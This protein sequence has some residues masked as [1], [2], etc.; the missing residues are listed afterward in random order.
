[1]IQEEDQNVTN[2]IPVLSEIP[3]FGEIFKNHHVVHTTSELVIF[4]TPRVLG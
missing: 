2:G 1:M 4:V 3:L